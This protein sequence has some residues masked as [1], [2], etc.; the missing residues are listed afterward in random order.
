MVKALAY[1]LAATRAAFGVGF[2]IAPAKVSEGWVGR[3]ARSPQIDVLSR[4]LG[5]RDLVLGAGGGIALATGS[6]PRAWYA[7]QVV[8]DTADLVS[9]ALAGK[10]LPKSGYR[11]GMAMAGGSAIFAAAV[12]LGLREVEPAAD[13]P[14]TP[15]GRQG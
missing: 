12:A 15:S 14:P 8:S 2:L 4:A 11:L 10:R 5:A 7:A 6:Q 9:T 1:T 13:A 3:K